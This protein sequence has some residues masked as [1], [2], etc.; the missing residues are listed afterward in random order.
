MKK[1][2]FMLLAAF[3]AVTAYAGGPQKRIMAE[4]M[5]PANVQ[6]GQKLNLKQASGKMLGKVQTSRARAPKKAVDA[7]A[8]VGDYTWNFQQAN[9]LSTD[10]ESLETSASSARVTIAESETGL[11]VSGMFSNALEAKLESYEDGD[12]IVIAGGQVAGTSSYGDYVLNGMFYYEGDE[13]N[14]ADWYYTDIYGQVLEDGSI[15]FGNWMC[16]VLSGGQYD[17]YS[18]TPYFVAG[19]TLTPAEPLSPITVPEGLTTEEYS[20][21]ARNYK[22]DADV[23]GSVQIGFDGNDVYVQGFCTYIP[24]AWAKGTLE[25]TTIT[26]TKGQYFGTYADT[27]DMYLNVLMDEDVVFDYDAEAGTLTAQNEFFLVDNSDYYF[28]SYRGAVLKKVIE[29]AAMPANPAITSLQNG[30][31]GWYFNFNVPTVD[32]NGDGLATSKL[33]YMIYTDVEGEIAPL[34]FTPATHT[35][36]TEDMTEIPYGFTENYDFYTDAI[37]LNELYSANWNNLGIQSIYYGGDE[38]NATEIQ[39]FHIKDYT[40]PVGPTVATFNFNEM[41]VATSSNVTHDGDITETLELTAENV[42]LAISPKDESASNENRFWGTNAGPQLRLYSGTLTFSVPEGNLITQIVFNYGKW[43]DGNTADP[44]TFANDAEAKVATWTPAEGEELTSQVV[45]TIAANTQINS[46]EVT[47]ESEGGSVEPG[48][49]IDPDGI[50]YTFD[51]GTLQGWTTIDADGDGYNWINTSEADDTGTKLPG[52][53]GEGNFAV[54]S[55]SYYNQT[56]LTPDNYLVSP[57]IKLGSTFR[58]YAVAQDAAYPVEHFGVAVSTSGKDVAN[59]EMVDEWD[60]KAVRHNGPR[61]AQGNWYEFAVDMS[62]YQGEEGYVAIRHFNCTDMF[63][64]LVDDISFGDPDIEINPAEGVVEQL[65]EFILTFNKYDVQ[66]IETEASA[67]LLNE[68]TGTSLSGTVN[69]GGNKLTVSFEA[70]TE[71]GNYTMTVTGVQT[72]EGVPVELSFNYTIKMPKV[73]VALPDGVEPEEYTLEAVGSDGENSY[74]ITGTKLVA[75]DGTDVYLQGLAYFFPEAY[76]KGSLTEDGQVLVPSGQYVGTD[77]YGDEFLVA[78]DVD[79]ENKL[80]DAASGVIAFDY[81]A[82]SGVISL[83]EGTYYGESGSQDTESLYNYFYSAVYTP[84]AYVLPDVVELPEGAEVNTW[85]LS[86]NDSEDAAVTREVGVAFVENDIYVQGLCEYLPEAWV[87][88]TI[89]GE[90]ATFAT[91]QFYG[92]YAEQYNLFFVGYGAEVKDVVFTY[93]AVNGLLTTEDY[94]MLAGDQKANSF[95]DYYSNVEISRDRPDSFPVEAPE[96]LETETYLFSANQIVANEG[97]GELVTTEVTFDFNTMD[98][99]TSNNDGGTDGDITEALTITEGNVILTVS[100][101]EESATTENRFWGTTAG[102]QLRVYSGTL[103]FSVPEGYVMKQIVFN[104]N[105]DK[106]NDGNSADSGEFEGTTWTGNAQA[107]VVTIAGNS[108][109][110]SIAVTVAEEG[111]EPE[112]NYTPYEFQTQVGF[113]GQ[114]VYFKGFSDDTAEYWAKGTLSEDGKT[115]TIP[116]NQ[117]MGRL[118]F[119]G[120]VFDYFVTAVDE[121]GNMVDLVLNYDAETSTFTTSQTMMLNGSKTEQDPYQTFTDVVITKMADFAATPADPE[122]TELKTTETNYPKAYFNIPAEDVEGNALLTSKLFYTVWIE[123]EGEEKQFVVVAGAYEQATEDM[124]EI[125]YDYDDSWDIYKGGS[126]FFFNP[127]EAVMTWKKIGVQSIYYGGGE[128]NVSNIVW[129]DNPAYD[130]STGISSVMS[131]NQKEDVI[132]NLSGQRVQKAQKGIYIVNGK[133]IAVK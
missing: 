69:G 9:E 131:N 82:E 23:S 3:I 105:N 40:G 11:T 28:D 35:R 72:T 59:F 111:D 42:T 87:K 95:Y 47:V 27:Y 44:G 70:T 4:K 110:N 30:N 127:V 10:I 48:E 61:K 38:T 113:D 116:A 53:G 100:P 109:I 86:A 60:L 45:V 90:T 130:P 77:S 108:Q 97:D 101:K 54:F 103:T 33:Y 106:W 2:T 85:Y 74:S 36:L 64:I 119:W 125:P 123:E 124:T 17:G 31:Y 81:D 29:K 37:Y 80:I 94:I 93:D 22:D 24:E 78:L 121:D 96:G 115:V 16:R 18:L 8:L 89:D 118:E 83:A 34:T 58:F 104:I 21:S 26:F 1:F 51:D 88:G 102:P 133:K 39:W 5:I 92:T 12:F 99:A 75:F 132:Y 68:T 14:E 25:G 65:G 71:P 15:Y 128:R 120:Y 117:Y 76:V 32:I 107:V 43:N 63:Y 67:T 79:E 55:Q 52:H 122:I 20:L 114:D 84:G 73:L 50:T 66:V 41:D 98:V 91:G 129:M 19:S 49:A 57:K 6:M 7:S 46:I 13:E 56:A 126:T 62:K 112:P